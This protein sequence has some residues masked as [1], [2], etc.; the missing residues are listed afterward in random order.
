MY[1]IEYDILKVFLR[2]FNG[3]VLRK[4]ILCICFC[5][6]RNMVVEDVLKK[7]RGIWRV[8]MRKYRKD[9]EVIIINLGICCFL[10]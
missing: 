2:V 8:V 5:V 3:L 9:L 1:F 7:V 6:K 4:S 10:D